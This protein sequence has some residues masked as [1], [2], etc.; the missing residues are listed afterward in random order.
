PS[1]VG[2]SS[3]V[4]AGLLPALRASTRADRGREC[5]V[6]V[7]RPGRIPLHRLASVLEEAPG[8]GMH[9]LQQLV[10]APG[11]FGVKLRDAAVRRGTSVVVV[12]D[13]LEELFTLCDSDEVRALFLG[14]LLAAADDPSSP[15]RVVLAMRADFLDRLAGHKH[16][17]AELSRGL[18]FL[19]APDRDNLRETL[20]RPAELAGYQFEDPQIV[21]DMLQVATSRGALPLVSFAAA[22]LWEARD[23]ERKLLT[24]AAY[25][26]MGGVG[27]AF[28]R[29]ADQVASAI[30]P[31]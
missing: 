22:R 12:V 23:R 7:L 17:L 16:V 2:K 25:Q 1:G 15:V 30:P 24:R 28:A 29:H 9:L 31:Q 18:F 19:T 6:H 26:Q 11:L 8:Q 3:F 20:L 21:E 4:H 27:G 13:Q 14:A 10:E 5:Q